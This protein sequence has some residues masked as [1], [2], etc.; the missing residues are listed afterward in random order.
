MQVLDRVFWVAGPA[1]AA[2]ATG[3]KARQCR[4]E[5]TRCEPSP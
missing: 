2:A 5:S 4:K 3:N 1:A